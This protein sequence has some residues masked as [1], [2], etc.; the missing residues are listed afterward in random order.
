MFPIYDGSLFQAR[1]V[2]K[3]RDSKGFRPHLH[4]IIPISI[5]MS[6]HWR[7]YS[8]I[9]SSK[10]LVLHQLSKK[11]YAW[12]MF[13]LPYIK[14][15]PSEY[16]GQCFL[17]SCLGIIILISYLISFFNS[18]HRISTYQLHSIFLSIKHRW[19]LYREKSQK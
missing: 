18:S 16:F 15:A 12:K 19:L 13:S 1:Y 10:N 7:Y 2:P 9:I 5:F 4:H 6:F 14:K 11:I 8:N 3:T 17:Y